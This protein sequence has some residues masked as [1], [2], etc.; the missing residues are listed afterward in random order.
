[1]SKVFNY[2]SK[3]PCFVWASN[4]L[5]LGFGHAALFFKHHAHDMLQLP[6][7]TSLER[8]QW[9]RLKHYF[10]GTSYLSFLFSMLRGHSRSREEKYRFVN[11][12]AL[13]Y[14]FDD[15]ADAWQRNKEEIHTYG[16]QGTIKEYGLH[17]DQSGLALHLLKNIEDSLP[18][19]RNQQFEGY[20]ERV[21]RVETEG[22][23]LQ[24]ATMTQSD[25]MRITR[26]KGGCSVLMF[27][28]MLKDEIGE[29]EIDAWYRFG[30]LIQ[31]CDDIFDIW[32]DKQEGVTTLATSVQTQSDLQNLTD[33]FEQ[34][35]AETYTALQNCNASR[36]QRCTTWYGMHYM[37][38]LTRLCLTHYARLIRRDGNLATDHRQ[39][40]VL[41]MEKW[42]N[43]FL[44]IWYCLRF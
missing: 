38:A 8:K 40:L 20:M 36:K 34:E 18:I 30:G 4:W 16:W 39:T 3:I 24:T 17:A 44:A 7:H 29:K 1:L 10:Y 5:V 13:A 31:L 32:F 21:F 22:R 26:E 25:L 42:N 9:R 23:Q 15:L 35:V 14:H 6:E 12:S 11:L 37:I 33:R 2:I 19:A 27:R 41:D 43:R 28:M